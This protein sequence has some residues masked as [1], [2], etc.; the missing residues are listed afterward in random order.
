MVI[1]IGPLLM[2][3][4]NQMAAL[5][6]KGVDI[7]FFNSEQMHEEVD[8]H[9]WL[10]HRI[11]QQRPNLIHM[12]LEKL[13]HSSALT[14]ILRQLYNKKHLKGCVLDEGHSAVKWGWNF[15]YSN[16]SIGSSTVSAKVFWAFRSWPLTVTMT[17]HFSQSMKCP[18]LNYEAWPKKKVALQEIAQFI[19]ESHA[20]ETGIIYAHSCKLCEEITYKLKEEHDFD[21]RH[22]HAKV[23]SRD[24]AETLDSWKMDECQVIIATI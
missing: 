14:L 12:M 23:D 4:Q 9:W 18:N 8:V 22:F 6:D 11:K 17:T 10:L 7:A 2:L 15:R 1:V 21:A 13:K 24:K 3:M 5:Q 16:H 19:K 20:G